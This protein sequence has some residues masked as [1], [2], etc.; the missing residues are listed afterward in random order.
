MRKK[1]IWHTFF[2]EA[3]GLL[4]LAGLAGFG[5]NHLRADGLPL[6]ARPEAPAAENGGL[7]ELS[8]AQ[9]MQS[10]TT[11]DVIFVDARTPLDYADGHVRGAVNLPYAAAK[12]HTGPVRLVIYCS[13]DTC[14]MAAN[15]GELLLQRGLEVAI[16]P[17]GVAGWFASGGLME[18]GK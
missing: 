5:S 1:N 18:T 11:G 8:P 17:K 12:D 10:A 3:L 6:G 2:W 15:L 9:A 4:L 13:G 14:G 7:L 16:M